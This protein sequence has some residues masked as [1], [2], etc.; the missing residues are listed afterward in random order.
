MKILKLKSGTNEQ[1]NYTSLNYNIYFTS[2]Q[3]SNKYL[4]YLND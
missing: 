3:E 4:S 1:Y 2:Y